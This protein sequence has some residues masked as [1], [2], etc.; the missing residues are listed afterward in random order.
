MCTV[1]QYE[2]DLFEGARL[3]NVQQVLCALITHKVDVNTCDN[4]RVVELVQVKR[5][6]GK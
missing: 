1:T 6:K 5:K 2:L 4:V 3:N